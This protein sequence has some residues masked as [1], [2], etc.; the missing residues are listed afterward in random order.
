MFRCKLTIF[1]LLS[2]FVLFKSYAAQEWQDLSVFKVNTEK[3]RATFVPYNSVEQVFDDNHFS[4]DRYKLLNGDWSFKWSRTPALTPKNFFESNYNVSKWS[5]IPVPS[6]WQMHGYDYPI[7]TNIRYPFPLN[8]PYVPDDFNPTGAYVTE[9]DVPE[10]W[11]GNNVFIHLGAVK[12]AFYIWVNGKKVGYSEGSKTPAE[13]NLTPYLINGTNRLALKVLRY[14]DGSYLEDQDFWR[15][16]GIERDVYLYTTPDVQIRDFFAKATLSDDYKNGL[17]DLDIDV[18]NLAPKSSNNIDVISTLYD[19]DKNIVAVQSSKVELN[20]QEQKSLTHSFFI[21]NIKPWSAETPQLYSLVIETKDEKTGTLE[22]VGEDIGF[23]TVELKNGQLI[24]NGQAILIKGVNRHEH[25][26][27][28]AHVISRESMLEDVRLIKQN[29]INAVRTAHYPNDPYFYSLAD[30]YGLYVIDEANVETHGFGYEPDT[31]LA[32][33]PEWEAKTMDR[34]VRMVERDKNHPSII[35]WSMGNEAG[36]GPVFINAYKWLKKKDPTRLVSYERAEL[37]EQFKERHVDANTMMYAPMEVVKNDYLDKDATRPFFWIEYAHAMGNSTGNFKDYWDMVR[38][39]PQFQGGFIWDWADQGLI[40]KDSQ[41]N[42]FWGYGGD[43]EPEGTYNNSNFCL[44]GLVNPDRTPHPAL[45]E[46]KKV[47]QDVQFKQL[48]DGKFEIYNEHFFVDTSDLTFTW[49]LLENGIEVDSG[50]F[51]K[52]IQPQQ[53]VVIDLSD[54]LKLSKEAEYHLNFSAVTNITQPLITK[55][56]EQATAQFQIQKV[57]QT[58]FKQN[59]PGQ[60]VLKR[61]D[62]KTILVGETFKLEFDESGY[63]SAYEMQ[64]RQVIKQPLKLNFWRDPTDNDFGNKMPK[65]ANKWKLASANQIGLGIEVKKHAQGYIVLQQIVKLQ[66]VNAK[67][68]I[69]YTINTLGEIKIDIALNIENTDGISVLPKFGTNLQLPVSFDKV[70]Y[71]GRGPYENYWD[72]NYSSD[73]ALYQ[74]KV[75]DLMFDY[76]RPQENGYRTDTRWV[77]FTDSSGVGLKF[78]GMPLLSFS[79]HH[80]LNGDFDPGLKKA[81][82]HYTDIKKRDLVNINI[83]Y[84]QMGLGGDDSWGAKTHKQYTLPPRDYQFSFVI[85]PVAGEIDSEYLS[86]AKKIKKLSNYQP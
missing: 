15:V 77:S 70:V 72:R 60:L 41:G 65:W 43:F 32:N 24:V 13:F 39:E 75:E 1:Y 56:H 16:S 52:L 47:Y 17:L 76:I 86:S 4:S 36:D 85:Q 8:P 7:Y 29:N 23:R 84:K 18:R 57:E 53:S 59:H 30:K 63:L 25:D 80:Q 67:A 3:P 68:S 21:K 5:T 22:F 62:S 61:E 9:F 50:Q 10:H 38:K 82:R 49:R 44:N 33:K 64:N 20:G 71:F 12:S 37:H 66:D 46:V 69:D 81:Q 28:T 31:T 11:Q 14:S 58:S 83:D 35:Y 79:A 34:I 42:E 48:K 26:E 78:S 51:E 55:G 45:F 54:E 6:N 40:K 27:R 19:A 73:V 2:I 74:A